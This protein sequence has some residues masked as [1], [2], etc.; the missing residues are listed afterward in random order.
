[1]GSTTGESAYGCGMVKMVAV[2]DAKRGVRDMGSAVVYAQAT[3]GTLTVPKSPRSP[4]DL[5]L[6]QP[7]GLDRSRL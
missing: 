2:V 1:M 7:A 3:L 5:Q 4:P 6:F